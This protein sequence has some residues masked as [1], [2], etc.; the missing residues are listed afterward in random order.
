MRHLPAFILVY[1]NFEDEI[2]F[3]W[4]ENVTSLNLN[5]NVFS[6]LTPKILEYITFD[7]YYI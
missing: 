2:S 1:K 4:G 5:H 3:F 7:V 6:M